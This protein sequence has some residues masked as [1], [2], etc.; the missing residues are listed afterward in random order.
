[1][2]SARSWRRHRCIGACTWVVLPRRKVVGDQ[3]P[4]RIQVTIDQ[5]VCAGGDQ[6]VPA[7]DRPRARLEHWPIRV[8]ELTLLWR[9]AIT[10]RMLRITLGGPNHVGFESHIADE[11]VKLLFPDPPGDTSRLPT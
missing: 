5:T 1:M 2:A 8:R 3:F 7:D 11:H 4:H 6:K 9:E 10:P